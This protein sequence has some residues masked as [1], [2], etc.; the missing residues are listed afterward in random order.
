MTATAASEPIRLWPGTAPGSE[1]T[2][3]EEY[4]E[5]DPAH[6][7]L[8]VR[9]VVVPTL[10]PMLPDAA[11]AYG[12]GVVVA[13][14]GAFAALA[15]EHEGLSVAEWFADR[16]VA[17]FVLKYRLAENRTDFEA[18]FAEFGPMPALNDGRAMLAWLL[19]VV[20]DAPAR[21]VAD[22]EQAIRTVRAR[23][24]EWGLDPER[25]GIIGFSAGGHVATHTAA[26]TDIAARP[27]FVANIY[28]AFQDRDVPPDAPPYFGIVA[29]DDGLCLDAVVATTQ[30]WIAAK[31]PAELHVYES[32]GHGFG[33]NRLGL[34]VDTWL[35]RL[36]DW[37]RNR[38]ML[39]PAAG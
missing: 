30:Q 5:H 4:E 6:G 24:G 27:S 32:G 12:T 26:T 17:A 31:R 36:E 38:S 39:P 28:G 11:T 10:T 15:W 34:P 13:P 20:G 1:D 7:M 25:I 22:G 8:L 29:A 19:K 16:G 3:Y 21:A 23:A 37:L 18:L 14:G 9:N 33:M 35:D 2:T